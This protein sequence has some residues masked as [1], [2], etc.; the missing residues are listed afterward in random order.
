MTAPVTGGLPMKSSRIKW[1][2]W[3]R[4]SA[5][6]L[7]VGLGLP[8]TSQA[9]QLVGG[10]LGPQP[11]AVPATP[12]E[13]PVAL[14]E[15]GR[16][17]SEGAVGG[18]AAVVSLGRFTSVQV[19][20]S[21]FGNNISGD[22]AN[23]PSIA[24]NP[25]DPM[26][27]AIGWRQFDSI[28]SDFRQAGVAHTVDGGATW[29]SPFFQVLD[30]GQFRSDPV[31]VSDRSGVF[32]YSSLSALDS[33]EVFTSYDGGATWPRI[34]SAF[35]GDKQWLTVD[36]T[37][38]MG[39]GHLYQLWN[40]QF[41]CCTGKDLTRS[42]D[43]GASFE[44]P[45]AMPGAPGVV[46]S[47]SPKWGTLTVG[48]DGSLYICGTTLDQQHHVFA[49]SSNARDAS[50][51]P[52]F[53]LVR[54]VELGG[55][56]TFAGGPNPGGLLGQVWIAS[57]H[58]VGRTRGNIYMLASVDPDGPDP[59]DVH[60]VRS[61]DGGATWSAPVTINDDPVGT[62]AYQWFG[63]M[64]V[65]PNGRI[66]VAWYDTRQDT[67]PG[68]HPQNSELYYSYSLDGGVTWSANE[69]VTP[70]FDHGIG[71][72]QQSKIGDYCQIVS[73]EGGGN[74]AYSATFT[75]GQDVYYLRLTPDCNGNGVADELDV[76]GGTSND[77]NDNLRPDECE[78]DEDCNDN[79]VRDLCEVV[80]NPLIDCNSSGVPDACEIAD[81]VLVDLDA[82]GVPD[83]CECDTAAPTPGSLAVSR[84][85]YLAIEPGNPGTS[86]AV[87]V[88][89]AGSDRFP[90]SKGLSYWVGE[91]R[92]VTDSVVAGTTL[93]VAELGC[94]PVYHIW[95]PGEVVSVYGS[96]I[97]PDAQYEIRLVRQACSIS[98]LTV[99]SPPSETESGTWGDVTAPFASDGNSEQPDFSDISAVVNQF[100]GAADAP[101]L[102]AADLHPDIVDQVVDFM[103]I[104]DAVG[105]FLGEPFPYVGPIACLNKR[106][107]S[108][109][110]VRKPLNE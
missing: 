12:L 95:K 79:L 20:L 57:D 27:M 91:P 17:P 22:A 61:T 68:V 33:V 37:D 43:N 88:T 87:R 13:K 42:T 9:R 4:A 64:G 7:L 98:D 103:D 30:S 46:F 70:P 48:L 90:A 89:L 72:P 44:S 16:S 102:A 110:H 75:G 100:L 31:L 93:T 11:V 81:G 2:R 51:V 40:V 69:A 99:F 78:P 71:Y 60:F 53:D 14:P 59:L 21:R 74:L 66:D 63:A 15:A 80:N 52:T 6:L 86:V 47:G 108:R 54:T 106:G 38:G 49:R 25:A 26:R 94:E 19:N 77:C 85:R 10:R 73:D 41:S 82:N 105:G 5:A 109:H 34:T 23:E 3:F 101:G 96:A 28:D 1:E 35:G 39:S 45:I 83:V 24:V 32:Y 97:V 92:D 65:A 107:L 8:T 50:V 104:S 62:N 18:P 29:T 58:S 84:S 55:V 67:D 76:M 36:A 56:T